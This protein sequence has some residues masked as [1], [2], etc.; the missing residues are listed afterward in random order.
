MIGTVY[1]SCLWNGCSKCANLPF[2]RDMRNFKHKQGHIL[3]IIVFFLIIILIKTRKKCLY[4]YKK[5]YLIVLNFQIVYNSARS[6]FEPI[7]KIFYF[8]EKKHTQQIYKSPYWHAFFVNSWIWNCSDQL[9]FLKFH[10]S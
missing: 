7:F 9:Y 2:Y 4:L 6:A 10:T 5:K 8:F 3:I 1:F